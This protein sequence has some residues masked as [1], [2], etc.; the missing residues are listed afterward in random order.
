MLTSFG[1]LGRRPKEARA[2]L[3][4]GSKGA[5]GLGALPTAVIVPTAGGRRRIRGDAGRPSEDSGAS[6]SRSS[7]HLCLS[8]L[9]W[10]TLSSHLCQRCKPPRPYALKA[11]RGGNIPEG[12]PLCNAMGRDCRTLN[13]KNRYYVSARDRAMGCV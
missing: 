10:L 7:S 1:P 3:I 13:G 5:V 6:A 11:A 9:F 8:A 2:V 12:E 4:A